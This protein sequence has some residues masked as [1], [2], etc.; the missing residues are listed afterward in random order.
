MPLIPSTFAPA[1]GCRNP[2]VQTLLP[3]FLSPKH[4]LPLIDE[5]LEL[6][7][8]DFVDLRWTSIPADGDPIIAIFHGLEGSVNSP[9]ANGIVN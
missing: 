7:D 4:E 3:R 5:R 1:N 9:Y 6:P 8:G 2:H